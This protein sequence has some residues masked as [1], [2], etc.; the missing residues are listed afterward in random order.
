MVSTSEPLRVEGLALHADSRLLVLIA[1]LTD[2][3][4][5]A[6]LELPALTTGTIRVLDET[7]A[8]QAMT[9]PAAF[10][11]HRTVQIE[12]GS[13]QLD[14]DLAPFAVVSIAGS[15]LTVDA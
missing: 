5:R 3:P 2:E 11:E 12:P 8:H 14:L 6:R 13:T 7:T 4:Q 15:L 1:S 10:R 9:D